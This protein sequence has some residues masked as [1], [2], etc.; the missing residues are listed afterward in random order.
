[1]SQ[2]AVNPATGRRLAS[3]REHS[4]AAVGRA[5]AASIR[6]QAVWSATPLSHR[7]RLL[8]ALGRELLRRGDALAALAVAEMGK[9][10]VQARAEIAKSAVLCD[11][12]ATHGPALLAPERPPGAPAEGCVVY[13]PLGPILG[14]M[15]WNFPFWQVLRAAV[16]VLLAGNS[17][18]L[19][20]ASS[21]PG[22]ARALETVFR[23]AGFPSGLFRTLLVSSRA[24][25][26]LLADPR[27]RGVT[28]TGSTA[29]GRQVAALAGAAL[30]PGVFE[31]G[32]SDAAVVLADADLER[33]AELCAHARLLNS[34]QSC[35]C[36]KRFIV[37][38]AA[39]PAFEKAFAAR[40]AARRIGDP[41]D[42]ATDVGPLARE[43][44]RRE[45]HDQV[46]R[47][48][49]AGARLLLGG[50]PLPG[51][52]WFYAPTVLT[53]VRPGMPA[54]DEE[55]FG[56]VAAIVPARDTADAIRLANASPYGLGAALFT[57]NRRQAQTLARRIE[58]GAVFINDFVRSSPELPFGGVKDSG[59]GRELGAW[60]LRAFT[61][62]KTVWTA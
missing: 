8:R 28:L 45:L 55:L 31:L 37:V 43:D 25:P 10:V 9:P 29:A 40:M 62:V 42:P 11:Y 24:I 51:P 16:P 59:F 58:A 60:G 41:A 53:D 32:G 50:A 21:V 27:V 57:R 38:R 17:F 49:V 14:V 52:G 54:F 5:V 22:C 61:N 15:P 19:K 56:P 30:K 1:M 7:A 26:A 18:L 44:L 4:P 3:H 12:Y 48:V 2:L 35:V 39:L 13:D 6:A 20:H 23:A 34:G 33:A 46:L 36:A 47:S